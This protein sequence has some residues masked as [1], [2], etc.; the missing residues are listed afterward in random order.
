MSKQQEP[1]CSHP[2]IFSQKD[3]AMCATCGAVDPR[4]IEERE[5]GEDI[6]PLLDKHEDCDC[7]SCRPWTY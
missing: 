2:E 6:G 1:A 7:M 3:Y 5:R 4:P